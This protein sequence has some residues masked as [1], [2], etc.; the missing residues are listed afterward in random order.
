M[1]KYNKYLKEIGVKEDSY[2]FKD[3]WNKND[4]AYKEDKEGFRPA[5]FYSLD[6]SLSLYI[7]SHLCYF[8]D[9]CLYGFPDGMTF[10]E[11]KDIIDKMIEA[12]K[13]IIIGESLADSLD[14][15]LSKNREKNGDCREN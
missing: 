8:R 11:W 2:P 1:I 10:E 12:F 7:Y 13:L 5:E 9:H 14:R 4:K 3:N 15:N 6:Y